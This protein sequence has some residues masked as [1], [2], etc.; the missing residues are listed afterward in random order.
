MSFFD[1]QEA[2]LV[3]NNGFFGIQKG[4]LRIKPADVFV[5]SCVDEFYVA[6][7]K[8]IFLAKKAV[9][10]IFTYFSMMGERAVTLND[11]LS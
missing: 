6:L 2:L 7:R 1:S 10:K 11:P 5:M 8:N 3:G 9:K 4:E